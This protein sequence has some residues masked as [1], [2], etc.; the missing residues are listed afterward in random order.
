MLVFYAVYLLANAR[1]VLY[2]RFSRITINEFKFGDFPAKLN[3][4]KSRSAQ[5][6]V[7]SKEKMVSKQNSH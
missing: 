3:S 5:T 7:C 4:L 6:H 1:V 2:H